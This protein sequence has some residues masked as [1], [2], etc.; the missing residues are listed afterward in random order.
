[1]LSLAYVGSKGTHLI[2]SRDLNQP[3]PGLGTLQFRR[4]Y[5]QYAN[6]LLAGSGG[7]PNYHSMQAAFQRDMHRGLS[8][9]SPYTWSTSIDD[10]SAFL[11]TK[12]DKNF[13][14]DSSNFAAEG[15]GPATTLRIGS[16]WGES[17]IPAGVPGRC[18]I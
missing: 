8:V 4:P 11:G 17:G 12:G 9:L 6:I 15:R 13:P 18:E 1:V 2:G 5:R 14:Q 10:T 16:R 3:A 7:N